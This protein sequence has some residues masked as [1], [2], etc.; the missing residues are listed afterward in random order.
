V[1]H[2]IGR[3]PIVGV[4]G[5][6]VGIVTR[7]DLIAARHATPTAAGQ[8]GMAKLLDRLP[9]R[10]SDVLETVARLAEPASVYLVGGTVRDLLLGAGSQDL[11]L[12]VEGQTAET[13]GTRAQQVLGGTLACHVAFGTCTLTLDDGLSLDLAGAREETYARPGA[14]PDVAPA[15]LKQDLERRDFTINAMALRLRP[16]PPLLVD[17]FGGCECCTRCRSSRTRRG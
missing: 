12:V 17:P 8:A 1:A 14:L 11:D 6:L 9:P 7:A 10:A 5:H 4:D 15:S 13:L 2:N 3:V 16:S